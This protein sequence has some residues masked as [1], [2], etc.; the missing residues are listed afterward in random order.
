M[1]PKRPIPSIAENIGYW[2]NAFSLLAFLSIP[3]SVAMAVMSGTTTWKK[4]VLVEHLVV[5]IMIFFNRVRPVP[6]E[7]QKC[8]DKDE[9]YKLQQKRSQI[10][11][12][13]NNEKL[14]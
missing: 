6:A 8:I 4:A 3:T 10:L 11:Q 13:A 12:K 1:N 5:F 2:D 14:D 9:F 7:T